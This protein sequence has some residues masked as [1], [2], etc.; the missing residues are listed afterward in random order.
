MIGVDELAAGAAA[1][2]PIKLA[3]G[4]KAVL[5]A[6]EKCVG[7]RFEEPPVLGMGFDNSLAILIDLIGAA[8]ALQ[9]VDGEFQVFHDFFRV[10]FGIEGQFAHPIIGD[11]EVPVL[12]RL[13]EGAALF[14]LR[15]CA[16]HEFPDENDSD[17]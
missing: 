15:R 14:G 6:V 16:S 2:A 17:Y 1:I 5:L 3:G 13:T 8:E 7:G 10:T 11:L 9:T 12:M 4:N